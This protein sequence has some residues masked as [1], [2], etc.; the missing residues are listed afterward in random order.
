MV[1]IVYNACYGGFGLSDEAL[2]LYEKLS[3][4]RPEWHDDFVR[5]DPHLVA[6]VE[7]LGERANSRYSNLCIAEVPSGT[8]YRIDEYDG[9]ESV[10]TINDYEW[11][12]AE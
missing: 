5:H 3:G 10:M 12:V 6:V 1:K 9:L 8:S 2:D 7:Q 11:T 4:K